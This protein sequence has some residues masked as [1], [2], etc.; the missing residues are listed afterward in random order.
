MKPFDLVISKIT[1]PFEGKPRPYQ[2]EDINRLAVE[3][4]CGLYLDMGMGK[5]FMAI[6]I[7]CYKLLT[8]A[9]NTV[10]VMCP[11][12]LI[13]QW[14]SVIKATGA[15]VMAYRGTPRKRK[16]MNLDSDFVVMSYQIFQRDYERLK[17]IKSYKIVDEATI[18]CNPNNTFWLMLNGGTK[19]VKEKGTLGSTGLA[20]EK[21]VD[22]VFK[23][24]NEGVCLLTGT[25]INRHEEWYGLI[26][27]IAPPIYSSQYM[28]ERLHIAS[29]DQ[30]DKP[31]S[32][33]E[34][35]LLKNNS[36]INTVTRFLSDHIQLPPIIFKTVG[37]DL[38]DDHKE[39][40]KKLLKER[41]MQTEEGVIDALHASRLYHWSQRLVTCPERADYKK[42][43]AGF[44]ILDSLVKCGKQFLVFCKYVDTNTKVR[45]RYKIGALF[46]DG[47]SKTK[48]DEMIQA[49]KAGQVKGITANPKSGG[50]GLDL[51]EAKVVIFFELPLTIRDFYQCVARAWR[52]GQTESV[53]V[54]VAYARGTIQETLIKNLSVAGCLMEETFKT[55]RDIWDDLGTKVTLKS[56]DDVFKELMGGV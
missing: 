21:K 47:Q 17:G 4:S 32:Y 23:N 26:K 54:V 19:S 49:F 46:G 2:I 16:E 35:D 3:E 44:E 28:F 14:C 30:Y 15:E 51:P 31:N 45:D 37:Y 8:E 10:H 34:L 29:K 20:V 56:K 33:S 55:P 22:L 12:T 50:F 6:M 36:K 48:R 52:S 25:P 9:F 39:V 41:Y 53:L 42:D 18:L 13:S 1:L 5:T 27:T 38:T 7:G 11:E 40:Y 24:T 43:T